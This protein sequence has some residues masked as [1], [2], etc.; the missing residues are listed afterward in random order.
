MN[1]PRVYLFILLALGLVVVV[2]VA[3]RVMRPVAPDDTV[4]AKVGEGAITR[5]AFEAELARRRLG[6]SLADRQA[7]LDD[8]VLTEAL[9]AQAVQAGYD[10][11]ERLIERFKRLVVDQYRQDHLGKAGSVPAPLAEAVEQYYQAHL[12][13]FTQ[14][15]QVR[16]ALIRVRV[17]THATPE[18]RTE[19]QVKM[20]EI[21]R[22]ASELPSSEAAFGDLA[23]LHS[24]DPPTR[25]QGGDCGWVSRNRPVFRWPAK[26]LDA[27]FALQ[28]PGTLSPVIETEDGYY[29]I[30]LID[31]KPAQI[32]ALG[33][34]REVIEARL[35]RQA[36]EQRWA[37]FNRAAL[38]GVRV[39]VHQDLLEKITPPPSVAHN[40]AEPPSDLS[41]R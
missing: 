1:K 22:Q 33:E 4:L 15:P 39:E 30:K 2:A 41:A 10:R 3:R 36:T 20:A 38:A 29:L 13:E 25:Y 6:T 32:V 24:E 26:V 31:A 18:K 37:E 12:S 9:Y 34:V 17:P 8:M 28:S 35:A 16:P 21:R 11:D 14:A 23:R 40:A 19:W 27:M 5:S 7:V